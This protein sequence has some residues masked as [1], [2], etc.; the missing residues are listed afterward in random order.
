MIPL[1][2]A[3]CST[4]SSKNPPQCSYNISTLISNPVVV[5]LA[6]QPIPG[7]HEQVIIASQYQHSLSPSSIKPRLNT[8]STLIPVNVEVKEVITVYFDTDSYLLS[9]AEA[10]KLTRFIKLN[11]DS[12]SV[13]QINIVGYS[14]SLG[15]RAHNHQLSMQRAD[16]VKRFLMTQGVLASQMLSTG[17]GEQ[18]PVASN[19][20]YYGRSLNRRAELQVSK[21]N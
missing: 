19:T 11:I 20:T 12:R 14:D 15:S 21:V 17:L 7:K 2:L 3:A 8:Q 1:M 13:R 4:V 10:T 6:Y 18:D 16:T 9:A 5:T